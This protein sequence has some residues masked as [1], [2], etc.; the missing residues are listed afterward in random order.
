MRPLPFRARRPARLAAAVA[1]ARADEQS[2]LDKVRASYLSHQYDDAEARL[3]AMLDPNS[4]RSGTPRSSRRA[5]MYL[6]AVLVK[7]EA[8]KR[9]ERAPSSSASSLDDPQFEPDPLSFPTKTIDLFIDA[10]APDPRQIEC[11]GGRARALRGG[12]QGA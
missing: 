2:E 6:A 12:T 10:R 9:T 7:G 8:G 11:R 3:R 5:R 4:G 1:P